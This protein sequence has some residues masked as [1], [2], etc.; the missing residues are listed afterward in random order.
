MPSRSTPTAL[1]LCLSLGLLAAT[2][3]R[4]NKVQAAPPPVPAA[5]PAS[6]TAPQAQPAETP[7]ESRPTAAEPVLI[8]APAPAS[9]TP[10]SPRPRA[11][12]APPPLPAEPAPAKPAP[13][14]ISRR[15]TPAEVTQYRRRTQEEISAA[16]KNIAAAHGKILTP[17]QQDLLEKIRGFLAQAREAMQAGEWVRAQNLAQKARVLS[18]ELASLL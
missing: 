14:Q 10:R 16:E 2:A 13:P 6:S 18:V 11:A 8:P 5:P 7:P 4:R 15:L 1:C 12:N 3:C 9:V 17:A